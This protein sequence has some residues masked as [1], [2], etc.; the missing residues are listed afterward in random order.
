[1]SVTAGGFVAAASVGK[2]SAKEVAGAVERIVAM[3]FD[4]DEVTLTCL[5]S[6]EKVDA[7]NPETGNPVNNQTVVQHPGLDF[8]LSYLNR[9]SAEEKNK[10]AKLLEELNARKSEDLHG[11]RL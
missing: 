3:T 8:C 11:N 1:M 10:S 5:K 6:L 2:E 7:S 9:K 4:V